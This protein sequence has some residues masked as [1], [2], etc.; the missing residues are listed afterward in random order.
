YDVLFTVDDGTDTDTETIMITVNNTEQ[1][2]DAVWDL[3]A[4]PNDQS[5]DLTWSMPDDNGSP[6]TAYDVQYGTVASGQFNLTHNDDAIP[7]ANVPNLTNGTEYQFRVVARNAGGDSPVSNVV[8]ETPSQ[9]VTAKMLSPAP[10]ST[11]DLATI[12]FDWDDGV[13]ATMYRL[14]VGTTINGSDI[15]DSGETTSTYY[16]VSNIPLEGVPIYVK[17]SSYINY[18]WLSTT[19]AYQTAKLKV[20]HFQG[21]GSS[22]KA[23]TDGY[24]NWRVD[25]NITVSWDVYAQNPTESN[26]VVTYELF[27]KVGK[28][29]FIGQATHTYPNYENILILNPDVQ[30]INIQDVQGYFQHSTTDPNNNYIEFDIP[31]IPNP[32]L[33]YATYMQYNGSQGLVRATFDMPAPWHNIYI[34]NYG[35]YFRYYDIA[36]SDNFTFDCG[37][38]LIQDDKYILPGDTSGIYAQTW[39]DQGDTL[40]WQITPGHDS[41]AKATITPDG[42][43]GKKAVIS[44]ISGE[45]KLTVS[46]NNPSYG[47]CQRQVTVTVG[48]DPCGEG[49]GIC[50]FD[51]DVNNSSIDIDWG[52]GRTTRGRPVGNLYLI[53][54]LPAPSLATPNT[55]DLDLSLFG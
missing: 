14:T 13:N 19:Y 3:T 34:Q 24:N 50:A 53:A 31:N 47:S 29:T 21:S 45:G 33:P 16:E 8:T 10:D 7:G 15:A 41:T 39:V 51:S 22:H 44:D 28:V 38:N 30:N 27:R 6:I 23:A 55:N 25:Y 37:I 46:V 26:G 54:D 17:L 12:E 40:Q 5:V 52:L 1:A 49:G 20:I 9:Y 35:Y 2:P 11:L 36:G 4:T 43:Q 18:Q 32:Q 42:I 48:C